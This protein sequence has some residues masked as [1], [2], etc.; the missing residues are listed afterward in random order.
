[1]CRHPQAGDL[2]KMIMEP[3]LAYGRLSLP[4]SRVLQ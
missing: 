2:R 3:H 4:F 1:M